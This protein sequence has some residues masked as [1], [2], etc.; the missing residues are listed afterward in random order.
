[1]SEDPESGES[2]P[3]TKDYTAG[4]RRFLIRSRKKGRKKDELVCSKM[5]TLRVKKQ[6]RILL[7][8][9]RML[10]GDSK[11]RVDFEDGHITILPKL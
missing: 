7:R 9:Q 10:L 5:L 8:G 1:M 11:G 3:T 4:E 2:G 6:P